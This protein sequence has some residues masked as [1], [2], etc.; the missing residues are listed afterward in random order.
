MKLKKGIEPNNDFRLTKNHVQSVK[1][2]I[3]EL[4]NSRIMLRVW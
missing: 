4:D 3:V 2:V 1:I